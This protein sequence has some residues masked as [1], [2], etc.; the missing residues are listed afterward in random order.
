MPARWVWFTTRP[1]SKRTAWETPVTWD[2]FFELGDKAKEKGIALFTYQGIYPGYLE[3]ML[4]PA[5]ASATGID[6]MK[7]IALLHARLPQL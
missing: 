6:N 2:D 3:S 1:C 7:A 4:W 5:L